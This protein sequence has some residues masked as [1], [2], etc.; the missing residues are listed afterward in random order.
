[1]QKMV[2]NRFV[3]NDSK[4]ICNSEDTTT[5]R[6]TESVHSENQKQN[7]DTTSKKVTSNK[8]GTANISYRPPK[9]IKKGLNESIL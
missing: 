7:K 1:M 6:I 4:N 9:R 3:Q 5:Q 8:I 2:Q